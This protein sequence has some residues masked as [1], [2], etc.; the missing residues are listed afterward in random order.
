MS[1]C[2]AGAST[3]PERFLSGHK[4][5]A[6]ASFTMAAAREKGLGVVLNPLDDNPDHLLI[7]GK[8]TGSTRSALAKQSSWVVPPPLSVCK[9]PNQNCVYVPRPAG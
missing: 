4:D 8:K 6:I 9:A 2:L 7:I 1:A 5:Y 3:S